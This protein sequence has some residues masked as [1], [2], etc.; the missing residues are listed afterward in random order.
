MTLLSDSNFI[1][2]LRG[3]FSEYVSNIAWNQDRNYLQVNNFL[4]QNYK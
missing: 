1:V 3:M 2:L 4:K